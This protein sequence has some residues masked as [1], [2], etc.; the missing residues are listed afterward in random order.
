VDDCK[1]LQAI[2]TRYYALTVT[3]LLVLGGCA[4][5]AMLVIAAA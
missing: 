4:I 1:A 2:Q 5:W 3:A